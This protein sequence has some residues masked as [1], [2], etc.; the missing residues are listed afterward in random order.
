MVT[1][2]GVA[3]GLLRSTTHCGG[4]GGCVDILTATGRFLGA[5]LLVDVWMYVQKSCLP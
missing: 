4:G 5:K 1:L 3:G 2:G